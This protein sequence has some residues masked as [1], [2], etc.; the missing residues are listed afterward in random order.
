MAR[1]DLLPSELIEIITSSM[2]IDDIIKLSK[3]SSPILNMIYNRQ[4]WEN[5]ILSLRSTA[6]SLNKRSI[7]RFIST[8]NF[9]G[10]FM[11]LG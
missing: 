3:I 8:I 2:E 1:L 9:R 7:K 6:Q 4:F 5:K 11:D 10:I